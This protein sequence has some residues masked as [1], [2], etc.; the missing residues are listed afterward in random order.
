LAFASQAQN[1]QAGSKKVENE[2][3]PNFTQ[4]LAAATG[5][6]QTTAKRELRLAL[7]LTI[8][9]LDVCQWRKLKKGQIASITNIKEPAQR[10]KV[11]DQIA[12]GR[13]F[14]EAWRQVNP[15]AKKAS[16][17]SRAQEAAEAAARQ[18]EQLDL[19]DAEWFHQFCGVKAKMIPNLE[20]FQADALVFRRL[21]KLR[22]LFR[23]KA[24]ATLE[25]AKLDQGT[26]PFLKV[27]QILMAITHPNEWPVCVAC[28]GEGRDD[29]GNECSTCLGAGYL[30]GSPAATPTTLA[31]VKRDD[32]SADS[33]EKPDPSPPVTLAAIDAVPDLCNPY[34]DDY[35]ARLEEAEAETSE[36]RR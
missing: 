8:D 4:R 27:V 33:I 12:N 24:K 1:G 11:V 28:K 18:D 5:V 16:G 17:K 35:F 36:A 30:L 3:P 19:N 9:Q 14:D 31:E 7:N 2:T 34:G 21:S 20:R 32:R 6:S 15:K 23:T 22:H 29:V 10:K 25:A 13:G 26:G